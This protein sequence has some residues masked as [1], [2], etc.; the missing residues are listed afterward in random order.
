MLPRTPSMA[1]NTTFRFLIT[2]LCFISLAYAQNA[3]NRPGTI[4]T[5]HLVTCQPV[6]DCEP[7][8]EYARH[9]PFCQPFGNRQ[10]VRCPPAPSSPPSPYQTTSPLS[11]SSSD[12]LASPL[13]GR[14]PAWES[15]GRNLAKERGDFYEFIACNLIFAAVALGLTYVRSQRAEANQARQ[16]AARIGLV[17]GGEGHAVADE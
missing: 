3:S 6:G 12:H 15:C 16:L 17:R 2:F 4:E 10:L 13:I 5:W 11:T 7:C 1:A 14:I 9:E 8:P